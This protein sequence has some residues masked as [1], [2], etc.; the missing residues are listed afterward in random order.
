MHRAP[1]LRRPLV[2]AALLLALPLAV[3]AASATASAPAAG[4]S[5]GHV[6]GHDTSAPT[7]TVATGPVEQ[8]C[9]APAPGHA[10]C[11]AQRV[12]PAASTAVDPLLS[13]AR[14]PRH[15]LRAPLVIPG[16]TPVDIQSAYGLTGLSA[17]GRT[18]AI[19][20]AYGYPN[21]ER[22]LAVY[23]AQF[24]LPACT[25]ANG[26]LKILSQ[27]GATTGLP[28]FNLGWAGEQA[29][30]LDAVSAA[31]PSCSILLVQAKSATFA[32]LG[33]AVNTAATQP[34]VVAISNSYGGGDAPDSRY[35][36]PYH[37][38]GIAV[39]AS[40][41]D[42]GYRGASYP[43]SSQWVVAVGGTT[44]TPSTSSARGWS[45]TAWSG[46]GSGCSTY[47]KAPVG[48][49]QAMTRCAGRAMADV[50]A[51]A[52]P[53]TGL[54]VYAPSSSSGAG[55]GQYGGT[56]LS[57]PVVAA[58]FA[59]SGN[60][61]GEAPSIPYANPGAFNDVSTGANGSCL[62]MCRTAKGWDGPT[63]LGSPNGVAGL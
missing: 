9:A 1:S 58:A 20:D 8:V 2:A 46:S 10:T 55:W 42:S 31:C 62:T 17:S 54:A 21:A 19:V 51:V 34:G 38:P 45:E 3:P 7:S 12:V 49:T 18:V 61:A 47:N 57:S 43:A 11:L 63:G 14:S 35:G 36:A 33:T 6:R 4:P 13:P 24:G 16:R 44:L 26:C 50:S 40:T 23:R 39:T 60:T 41:G 5:A 53:R 30:D 22:D 29:L 28:A 15:G 56:S 37:H 59:L 52:D 25:K 27:T 32:D 48:Q